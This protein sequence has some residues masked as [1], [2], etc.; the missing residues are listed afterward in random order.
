[1]AGYRRLAVFFT[2]LRNCGAVDVDS[3]VVPDAESGR[4]QVP[5]RTAFAAAVLLTAPA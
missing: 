5:P 3:P 2:Q 4:S 1:M